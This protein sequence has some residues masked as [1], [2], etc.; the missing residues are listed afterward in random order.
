[1]P[2]SGGLHYPFVS[3]LREVTISGFTG[4]NTYFCR[5]IKS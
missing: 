1:L 3:A 4:G 5:P 2:I